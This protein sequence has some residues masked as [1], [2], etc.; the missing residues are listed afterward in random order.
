MNTT[1]TKTEPASRQ[2][3]TN[4]GFDAID[5]VSVADAAWQVWRSAGRSR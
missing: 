4:R 2:S 3:K 1:Q 5:R